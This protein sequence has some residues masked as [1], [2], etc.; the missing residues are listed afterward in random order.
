[1]SKGVNNKTIAVIAL[2]VVTAAHALADGILRGDP[3]AL[4]RATTMGISWV[5]RSTAPVMRLFFG[6][7]RMMWLS[8]AREV[9]VTADDFQTFK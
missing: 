6:N 4:R 7:N 8:Y 1:M 2:Y 3:T 5:E 9:S